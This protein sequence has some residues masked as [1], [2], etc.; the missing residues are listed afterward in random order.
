M[1]GQTL[2]GLVGRVEKL[3][4]SFSATV[5][6]SPERPGRGRRRATWPQMGAPAGVGVSSGQVPGV[7]KMDPTGSADGQEVEKRQMEREEDQS[8]WDQDRQTKEKQV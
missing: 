2:G 6:I 8:C 4:F 3:G 7:R 1:V 5:N